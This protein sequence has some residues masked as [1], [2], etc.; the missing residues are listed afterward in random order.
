MNFD[1]LF[2]DYGFYFFIVF[3]PSASFFYVYFFSS[4]DRS[5]L[6]NYIEA[7]NEITPDERKI[8]RD[9]LIDIGIVKN[10]RG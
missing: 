7:I 1:Q 9:F 4:K 10:E 2:R 3:I 8:I 6:S 5:G